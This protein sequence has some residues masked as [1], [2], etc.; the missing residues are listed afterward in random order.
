[1]K[2]SG[3]IFPRRAFP[4]GRVSRDDFDHLRWVTADVVGY[5]LE[6]ST[7][8]VCVAYTYHRAGIKQHI[9]SLLEAN[10]LWRGMIYTPT[11]R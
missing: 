1:M 10:Q 6:P 8:S 2:L 7:A 3:K 9:G 4:R 11:R 5:L